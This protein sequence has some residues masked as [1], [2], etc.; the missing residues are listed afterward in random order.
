MRSEYFPS[1]DRDTAVVLILWWIFYDI[2][3]SPP[4]HEEEFWLHL[5]WV[6]EGL[7]EL[8]LAIFIAEFKKEEVRAS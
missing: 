8:F 6:G 4:L 2:T 1:L 3:R 7:Y 5:L